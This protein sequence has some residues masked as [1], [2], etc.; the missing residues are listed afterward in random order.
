M[1]VLSNGRS[2]TRVVAAIRA[3]AYD[4][5]AKPMGDEDLLAAAVKR[6]LEQRQLSLDAEASQVALEQEVREKTRE[7]AI[8]NRRL[9]SYTV[10]VEEMTVRVVA[11]MMVSL[12]A[13]DPYSAG[14][15]TRVTR[16]SLETGAALGLSPGRMRVLERGA[17]LHDIGKLVADLSLVSRPG[18]LTDPEWDAM[19]LHPDMGARMLEPYPFLHEERPLIR[20]HHERFDGG[21][22]PDGLS[23]EQIPLLAEIVAVADAY[24]A[25]TSPRSY[26]DTLDW[27]EAC[28]EIAGS[29]GSQFS[30]RV[31]PVFIRLVRGTGGHHTWFGDGPRFAA[32]EST[33]HIFDTSAH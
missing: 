15:S 21:G 8:R 13:K 16:Y 9:S 2:A 20:H 7:L 6:A 32:A 10:Q 26:Q 5:F 1:V 29:V 23:G 17:M 3:G 31:A 24:D 25:I 18:P 14:H 12:E 30:E 11:S 4:F 22:Y 28:D 33:G 19:L 27:E